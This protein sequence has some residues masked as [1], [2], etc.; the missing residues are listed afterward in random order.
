MDD[1]LRGGLVVFVQELKI[2]KR[3]KYFK[4]HKMKTK[5]FE[6]KVESMTE[7]GI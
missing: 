6:F 1:R 7:F 4:V 3:T 2:Y 5:E